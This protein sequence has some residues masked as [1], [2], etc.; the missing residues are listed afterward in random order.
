MATAGALTVLMAFSS[1]VQESHD[2]FQVLVW[3]GNVV[4]FGVMA[5]W[6]V[7]DSFRRA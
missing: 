2:V 7:A 3:G 5:G 1:A 6:I 4:Y